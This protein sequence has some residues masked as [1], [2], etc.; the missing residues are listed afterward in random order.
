VQQFCCL[1]GVVGMLVQIDNLH[2]AGYLRFVSLQAIQAG[3]EKCK[4]MKELSF[5]K[6]TGALMY[7]RE[8][9]RYGIQ[10]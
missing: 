8:N 1:S 4:M 9:N 6:E 10:V 7:Y 2:G 5:S 3:G